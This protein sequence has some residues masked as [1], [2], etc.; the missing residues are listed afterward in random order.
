MRVQAD[1]TLD[2][3]AVSGIVEQ[4]RGVVEQTVAA[5]IESLK[6]SLDRPEKSPE[7]QQRRTLDGISLPE[8]ERL[9]AADLRTAILL[10]KVPEDTGLLIDVQM[11]AKLLSVSPRTVA[12]LQ[13]T[14]AIPQAVK[15]GTLVRWKL[16]EVIEWLDS[17]CPSSWQKSGHSKKRG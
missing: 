14:K 3:E 5:Q 7:P 13:D 15:L 1:L 11:M 2:N 4:F 12:R 9:K 8:I 16:I 10:G 17:G 6:A